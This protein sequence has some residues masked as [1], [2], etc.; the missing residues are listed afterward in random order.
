MK[1]KKFDD[2]I[3]SIEAAVGQRK[4]KDIFVSHQAITAWI[5]DG[6]DDELRRDCATLDLNRGMPVGRPARNVRNVNVDLGPISDDDLLSHLHNAIATRFNIVTDEHVLRCVN[7]LLTKRCNKAGGPSIQKRVVGYHT[8]KEKVT[9]EVTKQ[10]VLHLSK[11]GENLSNIKILT[12][13][14]VKTSPHQERSHSHGNVR[15]HHVVYKGGRRYLRGS[16]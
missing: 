11:A 9:N 2:D 4:E 10:L 14:N 7:L 1:S 15:Q 8:D 13:A 12:N 16:K 3:V 6:S 5:Y